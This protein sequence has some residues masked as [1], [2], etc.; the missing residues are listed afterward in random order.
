MPVSVQNALMRA[1]TSIEAAREAQGSDRKVLKHYQAAKKVLIKVDVM[2]SDPSALKDVITAFQELAMVLDHSGKPIQERATK[3]RRRADALSK[4][5]DERLKVCTAVIAASLIKSRL[6]QEIP[7][8]GVVHQSSVASPNGTAGIVSIMTSNT[9][10]PAASA[11][12]IIPTFRQSPSSSQSLISTSA[13]NTFV[14]D[15]MKNASTVAEVVQLAPVLSGDHSRFL[16][17]ALIDSVNQSEILHLH[18]VDGIAKVIQGAIPGSIDSDDIVRVLRS[19]HRQL[20]STHSQSTRNRSHLL[21][22]VSRVL[23]A[24]ADAHIGDVERINL[25]GPLSDFLRESE[26]DGN[27]YLTFQAAYAA[28]ALLNVSDDENIWHAGFRQGLLALKGGA[29]FAQ[30]PDLGEINDAL[31]GLEKL[32]DVGKGSVRL[33][34]DA[35]DAIKNRESPP[36]TVKEGLKFKKAWYRAL[37]TAESY[38][39]TGELVQFKKLVTTAP[40]RH[41][42]MF[43]WG[44]CQLLGQ[45]AADT[46]WSMEARQGAIAFVGALYRDTGLWS[47]QKEVDQV[48]FDVLTNMISYNDTDFQVCKLLLEEMK[49]QNHLLKPI[50]GLQSPPWNNI[51]HT[52]S[53]V[54]I[55]L[56]GRLLK[57]VQDKT[58]RHEKLGSLPNPPAQPSLENI[59]SAL[60]AYHAPDLFILR[61]SG[62]ELELETCFVNLAIVEAPEHREKEKKDL[63]EQAAVF[64]RIPSFEAVKNANTQSLIPL[65]KLFE[66]RRRLQD[67]KEN[68]PQKILVQGRAGIGKTTLCKKLVHAHQNGLWKNLFDIVLWL[69]LRQLRGLKSRNLEGL[70]REKVFITEDFDQ[71][72][73]VLAHALAVCAHEGRV[74]F[75]LDGLDEIVADSGGDQDKT[76]RSFLKTLARHHHLKALCWDSLPVDST[77]ITMTG[78]YRLMVRLLW[79]K[80]AQRLKKT[81]GGQTL[82]ERQISKLKAKRIDALMATELQH[83]GYLAFK[84]LLNNHQ[85]E[86]DEEYLLG[87]FED[88]E[89]Y[90]KDDRQ[91]LP[92]QLVEVM[93]QTSF[94][95]TADSELGFRTRDSHQA[96]HFLHLTFQEY[97][98][99]TWIVRHFQ[100]EQPYPSAGMMTR[101]QA[102]AFVHEHKYNP[103]YEIVW[104]MVAGLLD[105][106]PLN[107]FFGLLQ[108]APR[109]LIGGRYPQIL[110][111]CLNEARA[112]LCSTV[113]EGVDSELEEWLRFET[114]IRRHGSHNRSMLGSY[115]S[116]PDTIVVKVL[117][118]VPSCRMA[119]LRTLGARSTWPNSGIQVL[120]AAFSDDDRNIGSLS[121]SILRRNSALPE[122][123]LQPLI[124]TIEGED[125]DSRSAALSILNSQFTLPESAIQ[126]LVAV[127][128]S[129]NW[130]VR[131]SAASILSHQSTLPESAIQPLIAALKDD[132]RE[133]RFLAASALRKQSTLPK[134]AVQL[135]IAIP[136]DRDTDLGSLS[137][138]ILNKQSVL[139]T[140]TIQSLIADLQGD[141]WRARSSAASTVAMLPLIEA[142]NDD[143]RRVR[144][145][146]ASALSWRS[147]FP[148]SAVQSLIVL[149]RD[150]DEGLRALAASVLETQCTLLESAIQSLIVVLKDKDW[151][152]RSLAA[153]VL[154]RQSSLPELAI[155]PLTAAIKDEYSG[156]RLSAVMAL[157]KRSPLKD[158]AIQCLVAALVDDNWK[159]RFSVA[160]VLSSQPTLPESVI[161]SLISVLNGDN[162]GARSSAA[163]V[164]GKQSMLPESVISIF[165]AALK[166]ADR[167]VRSSAASALGNRLALTEA[168][169]QAL[170][171][172]LKDEDVGVRSSAL[173]ALKKT[174]YL[175]RISYSDLPYCSRG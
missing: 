163:L 35:L 62:D 93:K 156:V 88:L 3:C 119:L 39:Q 59:R 53:A 34:K 157:G 63:K 30:M 107:D 65:E 152:I 99:A 95:H 56:D 172:T 71:E 7:Q 87:A 110:A 41:Q 148:E 130:K 32:Y 127:L 21:I 28:Q 104:S 6:S 27:P 31:D 131:S 52:N 168:A 20:R 116:F 67:G 112:R 90:A 100:S 103:Q 145:L 158:S 68:A 94:L 135:L 161:Q 77:E 174:A 13:A 10:F 120:I 115:P 9:T 25:H 133:V 173:S 48:M 82:T 155:R 40:C 154:E 108:A 113:V 159:V 61:V 147:A 101:E 164:L 139:P 102:T 84:G 153:L 124:A 141:H 79:C 57:T 142:L 43:Q 169:I 46:Q 134:E 64:H 60:K 47:R 129:Y 4:K 26:S 74:L 166:D 151:R 96:W 36:F 80:D 144:P 54:G 150:E 19:L 91:P 37:R 125:G 140:S 160:A 17:K 167:R 85:I 5:L 49:R 50:A 117:G 23:D 58:I 92:P 111:S 128:K 73:S 24:M 16:L 8:K 45:F 11:A 42:F 122:F 170:I 114:Q 66:K 76:F 118:S 75:I 18:S 126:S 2:A 55:T 109:D 33:L 83:L 106:K 22:A 143:N 136:K 98:A 162:K 69:P 81:A 44:I 137:A 121:A 86:F 78:L 29:R 138:W 12:N 105:G 72:Q 149:I 123:A 165:I 15:A 89:E 97:F 1:R 171:D 132:N 175:A 14:K 146:A 38:I 70:F 51:R